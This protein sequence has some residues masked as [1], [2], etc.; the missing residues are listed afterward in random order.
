MQQLKQKIIIR[1]LRVI[2]EYPIKTKIRKAIRANEIFLSM[3]QK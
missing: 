2:V 3:Q 1:N